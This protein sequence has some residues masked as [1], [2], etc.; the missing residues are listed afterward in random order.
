MTKLLKLLTYYGKNL[1]H[2]EL[3]FRHEFSQ[4]ELF[5][6]S[7]NPLNR[8]QRI[9]MSKL[10]HLIIDYELF[11]FLNEVYIDFDSMTKLQYIAFVYHDNSAAEEEKLLIASSSQRNLEIISKIRKFLKIQTD[12]KKNDFNWRLNSENI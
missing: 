7:W 12:L 1:T 2:L 11:V 10:T 8:F 6:R 9:N 5:K 4:M 3:N